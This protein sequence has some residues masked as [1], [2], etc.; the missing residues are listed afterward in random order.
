MK[1]L[2]LKDFNEPNKELE[3]Y[4]SKTVQKIKKYF[5]PVA[6]SIKFLEVDKVKKSAQIEIKKGR[7]S[8][9]AVGSGSDKLKALNNARLNVR[10]KLG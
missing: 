10:R 6:V 8:Y 9:F 2:I 1:N 7:K 3:A 4:V 5:G